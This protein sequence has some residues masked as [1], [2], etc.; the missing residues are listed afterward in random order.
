MGV[1]VRGK[2]H[3]VLLPI[4]ATCFRTS[5]PLPQATGRMDAT[6]TKVYG[7]AENKLLDEWYSTQLREN[8]TLNSEEQR[9]RRPGIFVTSQLY[10]AMKKIAVNRGKVDG[11]VYVYC[12]EPMS[13][14]TSA[15]RALLEYAAEKHQIKRGLFVAGEKTKVH[16]V[17]K[18]AKIVGAPDTG[19]LEWVTTLFDAL[20][21]KQG[22][23]PAQQL[24][25]KILGPF[26]SCGVWHP[27]KTQTVSEKGYE[28][29]IVVFDD[30]RN[31]ND[32]DV[33]FITKV[34]QLAQSTRVNVFILTDDHCTANDLC[35]MN[36]RKRIQP[37]P[38]FFT[39]SPSGKDDVN[40]TEDE[41]LLPKLS[42]LI[43]A[44]YPIIET[45]TEY[46]T[47]KGTV[48]F[49]TDGTLPAEALQKAEEIEQLMLQASTIE[50]H[51]DADL[52]FLD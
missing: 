4:P 49:V 17:Q 6:N 41:W 37:L 22:M 43:F 2:Q 27:T 14:K 29:P 18:V 32:E 12:G 52:G 19:D 20:S 44:H 50:E 40:W 8:L 16:L 11:R 26:Q 30:V 28:A 36:G 1:S 31:L 24:Q 23:T 51:G 25:A 35:R 7:K 5:S 3:T 48:N 39:G 42:S 47:D 13:G 38:G 34:Y 15:G 10:A 33:N 9:R 45:A 46:L 21:G